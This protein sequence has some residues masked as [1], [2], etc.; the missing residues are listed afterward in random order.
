MSKQD[1]KAVKKEDIALVT[2]SIKEVK[3]AFF[4]FSIVSMKEGEKLLN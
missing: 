1:K 2:S 4:V 3:R